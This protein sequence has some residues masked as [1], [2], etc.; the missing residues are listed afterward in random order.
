VSVTVPSLAEALRFVGAAGGVRGMTTTPTEGA[1]DPAAVVAVTVKVYDVPRVSP[2]TVHVVVED[3]Q[4]SL[5]PSLTR[6]VAGNPPV[7]DAVQDAVTVPSL[8]ERTTTPVGVLGG[9][10]MVTELDGAEASP[11]PEVSVATTVKV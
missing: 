3:E 6:Y 1:L 7:V 5:A 2:V 11:A 9:P 4:E 8:D 10:G